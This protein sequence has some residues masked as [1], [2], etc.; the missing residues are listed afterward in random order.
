MA[1]YMVKEYAPIY[2]N[3]TAH[4]NLEG[5][6]FVGMDT[7]NGKTQAAAAAMPAYFH[8]LELTGDPVLVADDRTMELKSG[9]PGK[10][11]RLVPGEVGRAHVSQDVYDA[12]EVGD[13]I[14]CLYAQSSEA[15]DADQFTVTR[16]LSWSGL[17]AIELLS[18]ALGIQA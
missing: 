3:L 14:N 5:G 10:F 4:Q 16:K 1:G 8:V 9:K 18:V 11:K 17:P 7:A 12:L 6:I 13:R 15:T 2:H